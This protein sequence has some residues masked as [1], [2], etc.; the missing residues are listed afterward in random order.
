MASIS[1]DDVNTQDAYN[2]FSQLEEQI[3]RGE[4]GRDHFL[5][6]VQA[7]SIEEKAQEHRIKHSETPSDRMNR[8]QAELNDL[9]SELN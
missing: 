4:L 1:T 7:V 8:L 9:E 2:F 5:R 3:A 6:Q